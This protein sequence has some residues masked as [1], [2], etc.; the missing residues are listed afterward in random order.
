MKN[1]ASKGYEVKERSFK[2]L[3]CMIGISSL[4]TITLSLKF[5]LISY[6]VMEIFGIENFVVLHV[7]NM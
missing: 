7:Y 4:R 6:T 3:F 2:N 5:K 1:K